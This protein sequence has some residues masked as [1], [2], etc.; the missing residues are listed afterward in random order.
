MIPIRMSLRDVMIAIS[1][2]WTVAVCAVEGS[3][4]GGYCE[5]ATGE[6]H[7]ESLKSESSISAG[8]SCAESF[9]KDESFSEEKPERMGGFLS[10]SCSRKCVGRK[11]PAAG[12]GERESRTSRYCFLQDAA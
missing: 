9:A 7:L 5:E 4:G 8:P 3:P 10:S 11:E 2:L 12:E 1:Y 6:G